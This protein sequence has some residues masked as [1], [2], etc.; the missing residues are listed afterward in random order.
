[1]DSTQLSVRSAGHFEAKSPDGKY[2]VEGEGFLWQQTNSVLII[3][4]RVR[5]TIRGAITNSIFQ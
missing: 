2:D 1:L 5:T 4:N 3:S